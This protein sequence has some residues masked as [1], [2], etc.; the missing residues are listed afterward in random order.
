MGVEIVTIDDLNRFKEEIKKELLSEM[1]ALLG[2]GIGK[3]SKWM[4]TNDFMTHFGI[5]SREALAGL[6]EKDKV[7]AKKIGG[8]WYYNSESFL[9][10]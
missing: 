5:K 6:R 9:S 1:K 8:S 7:E 3:K 10:S 4:R 2:P